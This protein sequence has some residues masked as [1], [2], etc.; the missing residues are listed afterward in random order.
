[1][2]GSPA[3][4]DRLPHRSRA[5]RLGRAVVIPLLLGL[6]LSAGSGRV[7]TVRRGDTLWSLAQRHNTTV[8]QLR[9]LNEIP[10]NSSLIY[11]GQRLRVSGSTPTKATTVRRYHTVVRGDTLIGIA[12]RYH[13]STGWIAAKNK[14]PRSGVVMLGQRLLVGVRTTRTQSSRRSPN[15][16][17]AVPREYARA[18]I[19][20]EARRAGVPVDLALALAYMESGFQQDVVSHAGAVGVMQVMPQTGAWVSRYLVGRPL[21]L[22]RVEDNVVAGVR[23]LALLLRITGRESTALAGYYQGLASVRANGLYTDTK[24]YIKNIQVLKRR[25]ARG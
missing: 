16:P 23:Y 14:L 10:G 12:R 1:M 5:I 4:P 18:L 15:R 22:A 7:V 24:R 13:K 8:A 17:R 20:A 9:A 19:R 6:V 21:N 2:T 25:F 3:T 11:A